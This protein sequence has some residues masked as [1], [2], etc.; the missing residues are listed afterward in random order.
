MKNHP[1]NFISL[2]MFASLAMAQFAQAQSERIQGL[3]VALGVNGANTTAGSMAGSGA[4]SA[5]NGANSTSFSTALQLQYGQPIT[6]RTAIAL[7]ISDVLPGY[8]VGTLG[9]GGTTVSLKNV[10]SLYAAPGYF[11]NKNIF[12]FGKIATT[13]ASTTLAGGSTVTGTGY[14]LG[15]TYFPGKNIFFQSEILANTFNDTN[16]LYQAVQ[17]TDKYKVTSI[18]GAIGY[19]F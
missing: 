9:T 10:R 1:I 13:A 17:Y 4:T 16:H 15:A 18:S 6:P 12:L 19:Q 14:G 5:I 11:L 2:T 7:G 8:R 3:S